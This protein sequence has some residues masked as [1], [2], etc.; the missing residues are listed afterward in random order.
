ME[1]CIKGMFPTCI[2]QTH[3]CVAMCPL[4]LNPAADLQAEESSA[5]PQARAF[6]RHAHLSQVA[7]EQ[8]A[9]K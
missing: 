4:V 7:T 1:L 9:T 5:L 2:P 8:L 3:S 6:Q